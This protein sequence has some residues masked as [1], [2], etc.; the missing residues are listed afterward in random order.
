[1]ARNPNRMQEAVDTLMSKFVQAAAVVITYTHGA[2]VITGLSATVGRT[3]FEISDGAVM[4]AYESR[5]YLIAKADLVYAGAQ[6]TPASGDRITDG[7]RVY[8][9]SI[10]KPLNVFE[11]IGPDGT[12]FKI[13]TK[14]VT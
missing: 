4:I 12:V 9:V 5:D 10:P 8:E 11:S 3:P 1:M 13:H 14:A 6:L 7:G 2:T